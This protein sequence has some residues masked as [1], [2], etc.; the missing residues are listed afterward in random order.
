MLFHKIVVKRT[1]VFELMKL[2]G[3]NVK[4]TVDPHSLFR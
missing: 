1:R 4:I 3:S 2:A